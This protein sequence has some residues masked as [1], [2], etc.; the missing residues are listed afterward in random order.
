MNFQSSFKKLPGKNIGFGYASPFMSGLNSLVNEALHVLEGTLSPDRSIRSSAEAAIVRFKHAPGFASIL[1]RILVSEEKRR[2]AIRQLAGILLYQVICLRWRSCSDD[3]ESLGADEK[4][5]IRTQIPC[6]LQSSAAKIRMV[7]SRCIAHVCTTD[8]PEEWPGLVNGLLG[9]IRPHSTTTEGA[10]VCIRLILEEISISETVSLASRLFSEMLQV[11]RQGEATGSTHAKALNVVTYLLTQLKDL[12]TSSSLLD[13]FLPH[14]LSAICAIVSV[15]IDTDSGQLLLLVKSGIFTMTFLVRNFAHHLLKSS[16]VTK[17]VIHSCIENMVHFF[18]KFQKKCLERNDELEEIPVYYDDEGNEYSANIAVAYILE[19]LEATICGPFYELVI[20]ASLPLI[21]HTSL[22]YMQLTN[23]YA[24]LWNED[25]QEF[26]SMDASLE[27]GSCE[28]GIRPAAVDFIASCAQNCST[29]LSDEGMKGMP[30]Q[31]KL[32]REG[33]WGSSS[34]VLRGIKMEESKNSKNQ[35]KRNVNPCDVVIDV[36]QSLVLEGFSRSNF[37]KVEAALL[38]LQIIYIEM[39][40]I[41]TRTRKVRCTQ[42]F[43]QFFPFIKSVLSTPGVH[44]LLQHRTLHCISALLPDTPAEELSF[45]LKI[46]LDCLRVKDVLPLQLVAC[47]MI[48]HLCKREKHFSKR[49]EK[50]Q[51]LQINNDP[52]NW[53]LEAF[54]HFA[55]LLTECE[56]LNLQLPLSAIASL[57]DRC[58]NQKAATVAEIVVPVL[59]KQWMATINDPI[60]VDDLRNVFIALCKKG[61]R[62]SVLSIVQNGLLPVIGQVLQKPEGVGGVVLEQCLEMFHMLLALWAREVES[63]NINV[64]NVQLPKPFIAAIGPLFHI[65][66]LN[67]S[68]CEDKGVI[69]GITRCIAC[70]LRCNPSG[71]INALNEV[72]DSK[73]LLELI[74]RFLEVNSENGRGRFPDSALRIV[75]TIITQIFQIFF[76]CD[77]IEKANGKKTPKFSED[78]IVNLLSVICQRMVVTL[79]PAV[80]ESL[81][82]VF[83]HLIQIV[84]GT[85][86][87]S[88]MHRLPAPKLDSKSYEKYAFVVDERPKQEISAIGCIM[89]EYVDNLPELSRDFDKKAALFSLAS[90]LA[91]GDERLGKI[92][93]PDDTSVLVGRTRAAAKLSRL[94]NSKSVPL[95]I[96]SL[97][98]LARGASEFEKSENSNLKGGEEDEWDFNNDSSYYQDSDED[99]DYEDD[100]DEF[101]GMMLSDLISLGLDGDSMMENNKNSIEQ[102]EFDERELLEK[103]S[104]LAKLEVTQWLR[105]FLKERLVA[106][107]GAFLG[108]ATQLSPE[109]QSKLKTFIEG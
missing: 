9:L 109:D 94:T 65:G 98:L 19:L 91:T 6:G 49:G 74:Q 99:F 39:G 37:R 38:T 18:P 58:D 31:R 104:F 45:L 44:P 106:P 23:S 52:S 11:L 66:F 40:E 92:L 100:E 105:N 1:C 82:M 47:K 69:L 33:S 54:K 42:L 93:V 16:Q 29:A 107:H 30:L 59:V 87:L 3:V 26:V 64:R 46:T 7:T 76:A 88:F 8:Y 20:S 50:I 101:G 108:L 12:R 78:E 27:T 80:R 15:P 51:I 28:Y 81:V 17:N 67:N 89:Y 48:C 75:D 83:V 73:L 62:G 85:A 57:L 14:L 72:K 77:A 95:P 56:V 53:M 36:I 63:E 24:S 32:R 41:H 103:G 71:F 96:R 86:A 10:L 68:E 25:P 34:D 35:N 70:I 5:F 43:A 60:A 55:L 97:T 84:G 79:L 4:K 2:I 90:L 22:G 61:N 21:I 13:D 102:S